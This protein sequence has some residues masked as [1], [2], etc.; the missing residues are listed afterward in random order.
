MKQLRQLFDAP[1]PWRESAMRGCLYSGQL[2]NHPRTRPVT[3]LEVF[4]SEL[5]P[6]NPR[7][8]RIVEIPNACRWVLKAKWLAFSEP[9]LVDMIMSALDIIVPFALQRSQRTRTGGDACHGFI[10]AERLL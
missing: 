8:L 6:A 5:C 2:A 4:V 3:E 9:L 7:S 1:S 10:D